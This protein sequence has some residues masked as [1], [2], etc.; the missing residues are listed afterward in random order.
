MSRHKGQVLLSKE[1]LNKTHFIAT[2]KSLKCL[3][4]TKCRRCLVASLPESIFSWGQRVHSG[5]ST[6][7]FA[8]GVHPSST[9]SDRVPRNIWKIL[10]AQL[11]DWASYILQ[12]RINI[13][14]FSQLH[15]QSLF[16][17]FRLAL[18][19]LPQHVRWLVSFLLCLL[20]QHL[21][22]VILNLQLL[23]LDLKLFHLFFGVAVLSVQLSCLWAQLSVECIVVLEGKIAKTQ[24]TTNMCD[25]LAVCI[26]WVPISTRSVKQF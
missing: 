10:V 13:F 15:R 24:V 16:E 6:F 20:Q 22:P 1:F 17:R 23:P 2:W 11:V 7:R 5:R 19:A 14:L 25:L 18:D 9:W 26:V 3:W 4:K 12:L 8:C 21:R